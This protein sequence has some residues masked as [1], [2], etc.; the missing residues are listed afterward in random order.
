MAQP[1][2]TKP[3]RAWPA[4][5]TLFFLA[6]FTAEVLSNSTPILV[7]L[8]NPILAILNLLLYGCGAL[9][10]REV[11]R[12]RGL[13]WAGVLWLGAAYGVFE[14]GLALNTW[15]DP[16]THDVCTIVNGVATGLCDYSRVGGVNLVWALGLTVYHAIISITI[17][18][19]LTELLFPRRAVRPWLGR[20]ALVVCVV[21]ES[22]ALALGIILSFVDFRKHGQDAPLLAPYLIELGL[23]ALFVTVALRMRPY[24]RARSKRKP[25]RLWALRVL[26][27]FLL[28]VGTLLPSLYQG[29]GTPFQFALALNLALLAVVAWRVTLWSRRAGWG[30]RQMLALA[31]G[32]LAFFI[33]PWDPLLEIA[34]SAGGKPTRGTVVVA[35]AYLIFLI[36]LSRR[37]ARRLRPSAGVAA[38]DPLVAATRSSAT[39]DL[40]PPH[41]SGDF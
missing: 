9:L 41:S 26:G 14:E 31:S 38:L 13:G 5:L 40:A 30:E 36:L 11:A 21:S 17:P 3:K 15:A 25:P 28:P 22:L 34:G 27:Y 24:A 8:T 7:F 23:M 29:T 6:P 37:T 4:I 16:W 39:S 35:L 2:A 18:I 1:V 12:R 10:V 19:L 32:V 20:K 33:F